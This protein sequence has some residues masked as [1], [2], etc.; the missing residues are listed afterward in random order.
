MQDTSADYGEA[1]LYC[2]RTDGVKLNAS[3]CMRGSG[4][5]ALP[6]PCAPR[7]GGSLL[8]VPGNKED[9]I[10]VSH[11]FVGDYSTAYSGDGAS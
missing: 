2:V 6:K 3:L 11:S 5:C 10:E 1:G 4:D 9:D 7:G 8:C